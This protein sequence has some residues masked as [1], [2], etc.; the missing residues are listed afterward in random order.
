MADVTR[1]SFQESKNYV[2]VTFQRRRDVMDAELN[3]MQRVTRSMIQRGIT[4]IVGGAVCSP[5]DGCKVTSLDVANNQIVVKAGVVIAGGYPFVIPADITVSG[6][7]TPGVYRKDNVYLRIREVEVNAAA[8][9]DIAVNKLGETTVRQQLVTSIV[10]DEGSLAPPANSPGGLWAGGVQHYLVA[11]MYRDPGD[12]DVVLAE[13]IVDLRSLSVSRQLAQDN[14]TLF[15]ATHIAWVGNS[16]IVGDMHVYVPGTDTSW[17]FSGVLGGSMADGDVLAWT[18]AGSVGS[19]RRRT[20]KPGQNLSGTSTPG[21]DDSTRDF[22]TIL[23]RS[24]IDTAG[25]Q[26][27]GMYILAMRVGTQ[28]VLRDGTVLNAGDKLVQWGT[29][30]SVQSPDEFN[31]HPLA[32]F[33]DHIGSLRATVDH[34]GFRSGQVTELSEPWHT[35]DATTPPAAWKKDVVNG[36]V[37]TFVGPDAALNQQAV[38]LEAPATDGVAW[39]T[40]HRGA[41][42]YNND[43]LYVME[44]TLRTGTV[45]VNSVIEMGVAFLN[46]G[47]IDRSFMVLATTAGGWQ[48]RI[49]GPS[50]TFTATL[51]IAGNAVA[52]DTTYR[53]RLEITGDSFTG[54]VSFPRARVVVNGSSHFPVGF[55]SGG[56]SGVLPHDVMMPLFRLTHTGAVAGTHSVRIGRVRQNFSHLLT[57]DSI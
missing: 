43:M 52:S 36:G 27:S 7:T 9:P 20:F 39:V 46:G 21:I 30:P 48:Y 6:L 37:V 3:E 33:R 50:G 56:S 44:W 1:N 22:I 31:Q 29:A 23:P 15:S 2:E 14:N 26:T 51:G 40:G 41:T 57:S 45:T 17:N 54:G 11:R 47:A 16:L 49:V 8:D 55:S 25:G 12:G 18:G 32:G 4:S 35:V 42:Y 28:A 5:D 13:N 24:S 53:V 34:H 38:L 19:F 10:V